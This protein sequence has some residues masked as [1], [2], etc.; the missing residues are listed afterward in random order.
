[1]RAVNLLPAK[2]R[3][4]RP[5]GGQ[6]GSAYAVL[7]VLG[8][9]LVGLTG[10][11][12]TLNSINSK[13]DS[14]AKAKADAAKAETQ[15][16]SL[17]A[18]GDFSQIKE[19][20]YESVKELA[21]G[22]FDWERLVREVAHVLPEDVWLLSADASTAPQATTGSASTASPEAGGPSVKIIGCARS[23][24]QVATTL[25]RLRALEGATDVKLNQSQQPD[26]EGAGGGA[27]SD[28]G[29][30]GE[31]CGETD[32]KAN[33]KFEAEVSFEPSADSA[34]SE[35]QPDKTPTRLGG[36]S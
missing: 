14:T 25:V 20:R 4:R 22:R 6:Q 33:F 3:P 34:G 26:Q 32:G 12:L 1:V 7:A 13:R 17:S 18:Y 35:D 16:R 8:V 9:L 15:A 29:S 24:S 27:T 21:E 2:H 5:T 19:A 11:V 30:G 10:Y 31:N 36:G 23:Q 28:G